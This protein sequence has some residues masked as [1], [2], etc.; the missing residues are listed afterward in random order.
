MK[1]SRPDQCVFCPNAIDTRQKVAHVDI[2]RCRK[3]CLLEATESFPVFCA[4]DEILPTDGALVDFNY[5]DLP[6]PTTRAAI[7]R[8]LPF[9]GPRW[10]SRGATEHLMRF[11]LTWAN[12]PYKFSST[13]HLP[14]NFFVEPLR[15]IEETCGL[16]KKRLTDY[17]V[18]LA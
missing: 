14:E 2:R 16:A 12:I 7:L 3:S 6:V 9:D 8:M 13:V 18:S 5:I 4:R 17:W 15:V 1:S 11:G 10:Y